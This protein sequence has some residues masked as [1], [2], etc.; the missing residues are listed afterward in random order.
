[1][2]AQER[3]ELVD[4]AQA[5]N[6]KQ[7][8]RAIMNPTSEGDLIAKLQAVLAGPADKIENFEAKA[9]EVGQLFDSLYTNEKE[10]AYFHVWKAQVELS[11]GKPATAEGAWKS[12]S[13][14]RAFRERWIDPRED[15]PKEGK[16]L[17]FAWEWEHSQVQYSAG[18]YTPEGFHIGNGSLRAGPIEPDSII[19]YKYLQ[20][21]TIPTKP[22]APVAG[23]G[24]TE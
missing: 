14:F 9:K 22:E 23:P 2:D 15:L 4:A 7:Y 5:H 24:I 3:K 6:P 18:E 11:T 21:V 20:P 1:M 17:V 13:V 16:P 12:C 19:V 10:A 8:V